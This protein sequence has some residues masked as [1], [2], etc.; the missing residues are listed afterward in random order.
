MNL[1]GCVRLDLT[2]VASEKQRHRVAS[3]SSAPSGADVVVYVGPL[4]VEPSTVRFLAEI[5]LTAQRHDRGRGVRREAVVGRAA[6]RADPVTA[7]RSIKQ[8]RYVPREQMNA[9]ELAAVD[10]GEFLNGGRDAEAP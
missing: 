1:R 6:R 7:A 9:L 3:L 2:E 10:S 8:L 4:A 5:R